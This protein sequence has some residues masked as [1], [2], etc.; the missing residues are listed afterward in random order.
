MLV[1]CGVSACGAPSGID[2]YGDRE[3]SPTALAPELEPDAKS[4]R[5]ALARGEPAAARAI[6]E[7][8]CARTPRD[9][10]LAAMLQDSELAA[11]EDPSELRARYLDVARERDDADSLVLAARLEGTTTEA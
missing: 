3:H 11:G 5:A 1:L 9:L 6:L 4:A 8:L 7:K 10:G 2:A